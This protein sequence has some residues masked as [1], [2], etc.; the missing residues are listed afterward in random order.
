M[1]GRGT[2]PRVNR[3]TGQSEHTL[4]ESLVESLTTGAM[5]WLPPFQI[6]FQQRL[7]FFKKHVPP[8]GSRIAAQKWKWH[9]I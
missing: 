3:Q 4:S 2:Y 7:G 8:Q 9:Q 1:F 5:G 6:K